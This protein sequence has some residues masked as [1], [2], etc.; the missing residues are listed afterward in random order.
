MGFGPGCGLEGVVGDCVEDCW[1]R[2]LGW[3]TVDDGR[4]GLGGGGF[5]VEDGDE[6]AEESCDELRRATGFLGGGGA[7]LVDAIEARWPSVSALVSLFV[8][9]RGLRTCGPS[10]SDDEFRS[11]RLDISG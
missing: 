3:W 5:E 4:R 1:A 2:G 6:G 11:M 8:R 7:D 9:R 10:S